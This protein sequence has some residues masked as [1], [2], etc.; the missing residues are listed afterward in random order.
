MKPA[1]AR[2][3]PASYP[4]HK[5]V[6]IRFSDVDMFRHLNNVATGQF[7]EEARFELLAEA[8]VQVAKDDSPALVVA[9]V[10][11]AFL[12]QARYPGTIDVATGIVG[13]GE[14]SLVIGQ[15]LFVGGHCIGCADTVVVATGHAGRIALPAPIGAY[16][17]RLLLPTG[18]S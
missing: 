5:L 10:D 17:S 13:I 16:L 9:N 8:R 2:L 14:R 11:T 15:G 12:G 4:L 1:S 18:A 6:P 7:Y 3:D